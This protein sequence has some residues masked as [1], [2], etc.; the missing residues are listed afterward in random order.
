VTQEV[1]DW[2]DKF[3]AFMGEKQRNDEFKIGHSM[4]Q[5]MTFLPH[6]QF[7]DKSDTVFADIA[8]L[9]DTGGELIDLVNCFVNKKIFNLA[10]K[11]KF[12]VPFTPMNI[13]DARG[14][15]IMDHVETIMA[16]CDSNELHELM[17]CIQPVIT[18]CP[19]DDDDIDLEELQGNVLERL[20]GD[21]K[22]RM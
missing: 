14:K 15:S 20:Q 13:S 2:T 5:S 21:L 9:H 6:F 3:R 8:G 4:S 19:I 7:D 1:I 17:Q 16:L 11:V 18:K 10:A 12:I 22:K